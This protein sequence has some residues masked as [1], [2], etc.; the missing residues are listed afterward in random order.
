MPVR[1]VVIGLLAI[2][3]SVASAQTTQT[4]PVPATVTV[5][6]LAPQL[7]AFAGSQ[8]NF[9]NLV[10]GLAQGTPVQLVSILPGGFTQL[11][12]FT[13]AAALPPADIAAVLER[14]RQQLIG[15]GIGAPTSEQIAITLMGGTVPTALGGAQV[16]GVLGASSGT[17]PQSV[18]SPAAQMQAAAAAGATAPGTGPATQ[19]QV[20]VQLIPAVPQTTPGLVATP[21]AV[22][23]TP[24]VPAITPRPNTSDSTITPGAT[25]ASPIPIIPSNAPGVGSTPPTL[26]RVPPGQ[27]A[28]RN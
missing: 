9:Q 1:A 3:C 8:P 4:P 6:Q 14:A 23:T 17:A 5:Q 22:T 28:A 21:G 7:V 15:F 24:S 10:T 16:P 27:P 26:E 11:V 20:N 2:A 13:P 25:S 18:P 19:P 12:T